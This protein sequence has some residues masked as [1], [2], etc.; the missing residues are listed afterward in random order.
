LKAKLTTLQHHMKLKENLDAQMKDWLRDVNQLLG[1]HYV[2]PTGA[3]A[4]LDIQIKVGLDY[5]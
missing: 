1:T 4:E 5:E 2:T 3:Q